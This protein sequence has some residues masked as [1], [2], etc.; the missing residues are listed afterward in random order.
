M[1][2]GSSRPT[3]SIVVPTYNRAR[4]IGRMIDSVIA[5]TYE[6]WELIIVD[7]GSDDGTA[8]I[9]AGFKDRLGERLIYLVQDHAGCCVARNTGIEASRGRYVAFL[10]SDDEFL[11]RKLERQMALFD[12]RPDLGL[13]FCDFAYIDLDGRHVSS[14]FDTKSKIVRRIPFEEVGPRMHVCPPNLFDYLIREYFIATIVGV[15]RRDVLA[16]DIRF[17]PYNLYNAEWMFYLESVRQARAGYVDEP[18]CLHHWL[19]GSVSRTSSTRNFVYQRR[20][21]RSMR[22]RFADASPVAR[23]E[24][25]CRLADTCRQLGMQSYMEAEYRP[26]MHYFV[27]A[28]RERFDAKSACHLAQSALRWLLVLGRPGHEPLLRFDPCKT[29]S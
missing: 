29:Q 12:L 15:V 18:L 13:V 27:E 8:D 28:L 26:A 7:D 14:V 22:E 19:D 24:M 25:R 16:D 4:Y 20:L 5:Q 9:V 11:P 3:V 6:D 21:L 1:G 2:A 17:L 10:D 23:R